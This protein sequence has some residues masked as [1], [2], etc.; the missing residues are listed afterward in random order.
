VR[1]S[2]LS[3]AQRVAAKT[4]GTETKRGTITGTEN[5]DGYDLAATDSLTEARLRGAKPKSRPYKLR[6]GGGLYLGRRQTTVDSPKPGRD[7]ARSGP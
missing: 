1:N 3:S 6:D 4:T 5:P 2:L 7:L